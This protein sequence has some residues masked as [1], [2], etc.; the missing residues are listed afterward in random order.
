MATDAQQFPPA[1]KRVIA[2]LSD[3]SYRPPWLEK[4]LYFNFLEAISSNPLS[5]LSDTQ[6]TLRKHVFAQMPLG[7][8]SSQVKDAI[9]Y[10]T[11]K[12]I[13][14]Q[15]T[16]LLFGGAKTEQI[17]DTTNLP[18]KSVE[19]FAELFCD[20]SLFQNSPLL[21][22]DYIYHMPET[23]PED[24]ELKR[25][26]TIAVDMGWQCV[27]YKISRGT[28]GH[29]DPTL[30]VDTMANIAFWRAME[31][32]GR[33]VGSAASKEARHYMRLAASLVL[34][35]HRSQMGEVTSINDLLIKLT[36]TDDDAEE[37][38]TQVLPEEI[39]EKLIKGDENG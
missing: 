10:Y 18:E 1:I 33:D 34:D 15:L 12:H 14:P 2:L 30:I 16:A 21:K 22:Q 23:K 17:V 35:K 8:E 32:A 6:L 37:N 13:K 31:G 9:F 29:M 3:H 4:P 24:K 39:F 19:A 25:L 7:E 28:K 11:S 36:S 27:A 38:S 20:M 5:K 26:Y